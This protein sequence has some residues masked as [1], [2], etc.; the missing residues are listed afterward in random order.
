MDSVDPLN[1]V[2]PDAGQSHGATRAKGVANEGE[3]RA[4]RN[5]RWNVLARI[6]GL[7]S[8]RDWPAR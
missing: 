8:Q 3:R 4:N 2:P 6:L 7:P 5:S 1:P